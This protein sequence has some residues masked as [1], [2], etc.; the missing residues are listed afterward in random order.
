MGSLRNSRYVLAYNFNLIVERNNKEVFVIKA[1]ISSI[2]LFFCLA[3]TAN[4]DSSCGLVRAQVVYTGCGYTYILEKERDKQCGSGGTSKIIFDGFNGGN[5]CG[6]E[7]AQVVYTGCGYTY[8]TKKERDKQCG[9]GGTSKIIF[10][11]WPPRSKDTKGYCSTKTHAITFVDEYDVE[12]TV[13]K[14]LNSICFG[15]SKWLN[16]KTQKA[17]NKESQRYIKGKGGQEFGKATQYLTALI[18]AGIRIE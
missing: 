17:L 3:A 7:R 6:M 4:A 5:S 8:L 9:S 14:H 1:A 18:A 12:P 13:R 10:D 2:V 15:Y 11:S 16:K